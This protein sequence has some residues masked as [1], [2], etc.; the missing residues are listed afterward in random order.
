MDLVG[1][2]VLEP[3]QHL[4]QAPPRC[5]PSRSWA[6]SR[7]RT[8]R[9]SSSCSGAGAGAPAR[10]PRRRRRSRTRTTSPG[11]GC[12]LPACAHADRARR[13]TARSACR[14]RGRASCLPARRPT[15]PRCARSS[16]RCVPTSSFG[17]PACTG[18]GPT[19]SDGFG[20]LLARPDPLHHRDA[21]GH[22]AHRLGRGIRAHGLV[23]LVP[24]AHAECRRSA[25]R[26]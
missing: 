6:P 17:P 1:A 16:A 9:G 8:R 24:A 20:D 5:R 25:G 3:V 12:G 22:V 7:R 23:V 2:D 19:G 26:R 13:R 10:A 21:V 11:A 14:R 18:G 15:P 4:E